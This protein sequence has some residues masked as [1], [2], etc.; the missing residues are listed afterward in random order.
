MG[1][2]AAQA[3]AALEGATAA[4]ASSLGGNA[5]TARGLAP[6]ALTPASIPDV[7]PASGM[8]QVAPPLATEGS[9]HPA[10]EPAVQDEPIGGG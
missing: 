1:A 8:P 7:A 9:R 5:S 6:S 3:P 4:P 10:R 2:S